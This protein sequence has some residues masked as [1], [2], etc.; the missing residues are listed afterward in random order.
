MPVHPGERDRR[1]FG[2]LYNRFRSIRVDHLTMK[3][4]P[5]QIVAF[6]GGGFSMESGN[7]LLDDYVL[8]LT[9]AERPRVCF[10]PS[11]SGDADHYIVRFYRAFSAHRCE[12]SHISLFRREQGPEDLRRHLLSQDL[13]YVGGGSVVSLLGVWRAHG[14]DAILREAWEAG[15][16][17]CGLSAGS[18]CWFA[19]AVTGFHGAPRRL[20]G[21][22]LL[23]F[24][25]CVHYERK[26]DRRQS[27]HGFLREGM[28]PGYAAEDGAA[29]HFTGD[30]LSQVVSSRPQA[31]GY[32]LDIAGRRVIEMRIATTF[33]GEKGT[34]PTPPMPEAISTT[35]AV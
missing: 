35:V 14:I 21:L 5:R 10:L 24:S 28:R 2:P 12:A 13:I 20:D 34:V 25:N 23:P 29:L 9:T 3:T 11:A 30:E 16:I 33:L 1:N 19:E 31:R 17:L 7:P 26:S 18:L 27:Y 4:A 15:V 6:G 22:G 8:G 32:R